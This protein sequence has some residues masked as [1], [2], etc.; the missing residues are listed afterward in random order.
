MP[1]DQ[2][3]LIGK[4][5]VFEGT[6]QTESDIRSSGRVIGT[7][8]A[9]GKAI[10]TET[11]AVE[12]EINAENASIAGTVEGEI[13][14]AE[15]LVLKSS[16]RVDGNIHTGRL[17][18]EEGAVFIGECTMGDGRTATGTGA[19]APASGTSETTKRKG[20]TGD[21]GKSNNKGKT[22]SGSTT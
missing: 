1:Q 18:V 4:G 13:H 11:G 19:G 2:V 7:L 20:K 21:R 9:S 14:V 16:A 17:V 8:N 6:I 15:L 5:T 22:A 12:G 10:V 3:N